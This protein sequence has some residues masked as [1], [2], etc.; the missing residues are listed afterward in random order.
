LESLRFVDSADISID[1]MSA[2][3]PSG[4]DGPKADLSILEEILTKQLLNHENQQKNLLL[5][6]RDSAR[7]AISLY[8]TYIDMPVENPQQRMLRAYVGEE[9]RK[10]LLTAKVHIDQRAKQSAWLASLSAVA[11]GSIEM[12]VD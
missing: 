8:R 4:L 7:S 10:F 3:I 5:R 1:A 9:I 6:A 2:L 11:N 12:Q